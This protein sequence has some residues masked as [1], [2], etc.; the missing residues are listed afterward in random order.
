MLYRLENGDLKANYGTMPVEI[1]PA[2]IQTMAALA[3]KILFYMRRC[4]KGRDVACVRS[5]EI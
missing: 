2:V 4:L 3:Q 1:A 5:N